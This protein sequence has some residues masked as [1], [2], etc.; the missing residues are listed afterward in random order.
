[1]SGRVGPAE[2]IA[3]SYRIRRRGGDIYRSSSSLRQPLPREPV[4]ASRPG[5]LPPY[6]GRHPPIEGPSRRL[7]SRS[8]VPQPCKTP[9]SSTDSHM[10]YKVNRARKINYLYGG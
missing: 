3:Y 7:Y 10:A 5:C 4:E 9:L 2:S 6:Q 8:G 1:G